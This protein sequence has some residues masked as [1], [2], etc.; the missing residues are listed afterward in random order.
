M[1]YEKLTVGVTATPLT[2]SVY[3]P[4]N[5]FPLKAVLRVETADIRFRLDSVA[6]SSTDGI[7]LRADEVVELENY[8]EVLGFR[9]IRA[10]GSDA[11]LHVQYIEE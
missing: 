5:K 6:P 9:A 3:E 4:L 11:T 8:E 2:A 7:V 1:A 10:G